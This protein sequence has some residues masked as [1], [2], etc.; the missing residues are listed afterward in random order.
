MESLN[1]PKSAITTSLELYEFLSLP[2][3]LKNSAQ[4]FQV[5]INHVLNDLNYVF[6]YIGCVQLMQ[7]L[8]TVFERFQKY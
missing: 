1:N 7:R 2:F 4:C 8:E 6:V 3:E 5:F